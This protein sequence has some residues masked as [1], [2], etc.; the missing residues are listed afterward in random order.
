ME[1]ASFILSKG[2]IARKTPCDDRQ[3]KIIVSLLLFA[4]TTLPGNLFYCEGCLNY[5]VGRTLSKNAMTVFNLLASAVVFVGA[6]LDFGLVWN[7]ADVLMDIMAIINLPV[8]VMLGRT[9]VAA[10]NDYTAQRRQGKDPVFRASAIDLEPQ[11]DFW[12]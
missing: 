7:L 1:D 6:M 11:T 5:I 3:G 2:I 9:A 10:L 8:I 4:F 12:N